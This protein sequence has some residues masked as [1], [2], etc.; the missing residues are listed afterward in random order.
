[1]PI[2][3]LAVEHRRD[4]ARVR[5]HPDGIVFGLRDSATNDASLP[6]GKIRRTRM[7]HSSPSAE[8]A[9]FTIDKRRGRGLSSEKIFVVVC[10]RC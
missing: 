8:S 2:A 6:V 1:V 10:E 5:L 7:Q 9:I 4:D 3:R